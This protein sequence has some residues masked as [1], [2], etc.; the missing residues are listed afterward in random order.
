MPKTYIDGDLY[1]QAAFLT[2]TVNL[3]DGT[4][5]KFEIWYDYRIYSP[6]R[7]LYRIIGTPLDRSDTRSVQ[8]LSSAIMCT[9]HP[10]S[11]SASSP[12]QSLVSLLAHLCSPNHSLSILVGSNV[13]S[14]CKLRSG[15]L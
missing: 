11:C 14:K 7:L 10:H 4:T 6:D 15:C 3:D 12:D 1:V 5:V 8:P 13:L 2:Q 9:D